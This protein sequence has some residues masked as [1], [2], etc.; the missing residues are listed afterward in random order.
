M[1]TWTADELQRIGT[2]TELRVATYRKDGSLRPYVT[3]WVVRAGDDVY[4]RSAYGADN[5]WFRRAK[6]SGQGRIAAGGVERD[7]TF[8]P[9]PPDT[10]DSI[11]A[12]YHTKYDRYGAAIVDTVVGPKTTSVTLQ[13]DPARRTT[14]Q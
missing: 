7:V 10:H 12:A 8:T 14:R 5:P 11:D 6:S 13:V 1:S 9:A 2:A 4:I 3:I